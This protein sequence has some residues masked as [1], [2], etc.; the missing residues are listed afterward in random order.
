VVGMEALL[1]WNHPER[2][3]VPPMDFLP[4]MEGSP[5]EAVLGSWVIETALVQMESWRRIGLEIDVSVNIAPRHLQDKDFFATLHALL[6]QH[7]AIP[8]RRLQ[9]EVVESSVLNDL[10]RVSEVITLCRSELE[11]GFALDDFGTGYSSLTY[12]RR[13]PVDTV[14]IDQSFVRD[15]IDDPEDNAIVNGVIALAHAF[16]RE[17][18]AEGVETC[19]HGVALLNMG[20]NL[21]QGYGI[22]RPM[23]ADAVASWVRDYRPDEIWRKT[24]VS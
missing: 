22:A 15:M 21:A 12:L 11:V 10:G 18:V 3:I 5:F 8:A 19:E 2:G 14:K 9:L 4:T 23:Q 20:C 16:N 24:P 7:P 13:L 17:V 1:R 6:A